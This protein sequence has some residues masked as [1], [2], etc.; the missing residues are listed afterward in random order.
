[1]KIAS[2]DVRNVRIPLNDPKKFSTKYVTHR[3]YTLVN[4]RT[5][6][7]V[8]GWS[9]VWGIPIVKNFLDM[10][11]D[12]I[13]GEPAYGT[14]RIWNKIF[15]SIDRWDRS[16]ISMR[17]LSAIDIALWD[18][19]GKYAKLPIYK[20]MGGFREE[21]PAYYSGGYYPDS[22]KSKDELFRF[23]EKEMG[24]AHD[25]GFRA[26]KMKIGGAGVG[27][28]V[29]RIGVARKTIGP[30]CRLMLDA[31]CGYDPETII[32]MAAKFEKYDITW[33]EEPVALDDLPNCAHVA[34]RISMPVAIG[35]NHFTRWAFREIMEHKAA[36]II[37]ADPTVMGGFTEYLNV[38]GM[39]ATYG[40]KLAPHC[41][42]DVNIQIALARP[43]VMILEYMDAASD[44]INVQR[45]LKNPVPAI[46]GMVR[47]PEG[48]GHG[49]ILDEKAVQKY[50]Y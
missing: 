38:V 33:V 27:I 47:A 29:E 45:I 30:D 36:R 1:M 15:S 44:V 7:G 49:L 43:E 6:D 9:F 24:A 13:I 20:L 2:I 12:M 35:E 50:L 19:I 10:V 18:I 41:F 14:I 25:K 32:S 3:D 4:I 28:D 46:K 16:G 22:C 8:E 42:H 37:Q 21:A 11:K 40:L 39:A 5:D 17:A 34:E 48:P 26:F 23:L 31:N